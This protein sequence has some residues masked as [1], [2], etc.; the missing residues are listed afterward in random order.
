[1]G[2]QRANYF[3]STAPCLWAG[4]PSPQS[5]LVLLFRIPGLT[6]SVFFFSII[7]GDNNTKSCCREKS[8]KLAV[9]IQPIH[10][11]ISESDIRDIQSIG[12]HGSPLTC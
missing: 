1:M 4:D 3:F 7:T 11:S 2:Y 8:R 10:K 12:L 5:E 6:H 9:Q